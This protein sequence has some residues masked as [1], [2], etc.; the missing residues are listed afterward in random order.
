VLGPPATQKNSTGGLS[1]G[2][3]ALRRE[4]LF[5]FRSMCLMNAAEIVVRDVQG[6]RRRM[7]LQ[8]LAEAVG[9]PREAARRHA[10]RQIAALDMA[11]ADLGG[12]PLHRCTGYRYYLSRRVTM[13]RAL[14]K[15]YYRCRLYDHAVRAV[16]KGIRGSIAD[17][18]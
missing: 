16:A 7:V 5:C 17:M 11:R 6:H 4:A 9:Q 8:L 2:Q 3:V 13:R 1:Q 14:A 12:H 15:V 10:K 18:A